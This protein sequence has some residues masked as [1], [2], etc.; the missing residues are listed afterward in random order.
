[1]FAPTTTWHATDVLEAHD[2]VEHACAPTLAVG[3]ASVVLKFTP[4]TVTTPPDVVTVL[5]LATKLTAG[6]GN[7]VLCG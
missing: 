4:L 7:F 5:G 2:A 6:T 3:V 1:M